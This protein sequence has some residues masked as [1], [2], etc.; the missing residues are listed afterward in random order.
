MAVTNC[1]A[2]RSFSYLKRIK[3]YLRSTLTEEKLDDF[4]ILCIE[5]DFLNSLDYDDVIINEF[6]RMNSREKN[7]KS[8]FSSR[9]HYLLSFFSF[10]ALRRFEF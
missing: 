9:F 6:A 1:T 2:E 3:N 4:G 5:G 10:V 8:F 7:Y